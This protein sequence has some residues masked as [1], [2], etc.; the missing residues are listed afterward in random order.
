MKYFIHSPETMKQIYI[1]L[2]ILQCIYFYHLFASY[3][4]IGAVDEAV[5]GDVSLTS[6]GGGGGSA[7]GG[8]SAQKTSLLKRPRSPSPRPPQIG[9][10]LPQQQLATYEKKKTKQEFIPNFFFFFKVRR[11]L[12]RL[13]HQSQQPHLHPLRVTRVEV[14]VA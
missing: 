5:E 8:G 9:G 4:G 14:R 2:S 10:A 6:G 3:G 7:I 11:E 12:L 1:F 13:R